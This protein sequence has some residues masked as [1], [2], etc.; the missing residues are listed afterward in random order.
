MRRREF[1]TL[2]GGIAASWSLAARAQQTAIPVIGCLGIG[3]SET[4]AVRI[5][6]LWQGLNEAGYIEGQNIA[7]EYRWAGNQLDRLPSLAIDLVRLKVAVIVAFGFPSTL[8]AKD[9]SAIIP[10]VFGVGSDPVQLGLVTSLSRPGGNLTGF[11]AMGG[12]LG[13]K[14]LEVLHELLT[15]TTPVGFLTNPLNP[16]TESTTRDV[17]AAARTLGV[18]LQILRAS[19][20]HEIDSAFASLAQ[21]RASALLVSNDVFLS[22][23]ITRIVALAARY[24][25]PTVY[26]LREFVSAGGL[27]SYGISNAEVYRQCGLLVAR[28]LKGENPANLPVTQTTKVELVI[29]LKTARALGLTVPRALLARADAVIE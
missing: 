12:E 20:E 21:A 8:A 14:G 9:A 24:A 29:N 7:I 27:M 5:T 19:T 26:A 15:A 18:A 28:I 3:S 10:I 25:V 6:G 16:I 17:I 13:A 1:I 4:E 22:G 11:N 23:Q 2:I